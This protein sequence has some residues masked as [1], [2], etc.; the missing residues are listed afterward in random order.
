M[1]DERK[2]SSLVL[3]NSGRRRAYGRRQ[4][5]NDPGLAIIRSIGGVLMIAEFLDFILNGFVRFVRFVV[6]F[7]SREEMKPKVSEVRT[8]LR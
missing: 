2:L 5:C 8:I 6:P 3:W 7:L 4:V 1:R